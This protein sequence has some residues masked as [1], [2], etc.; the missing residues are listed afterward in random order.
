MNDSSNVVV[1]AD[2]LMSPDG[3]PPESAGALHAGRRRRSFLAAPR[4]HAET[5]KTESQDN[6]DD[7]LPVLTEVVPVASLAAEEP[8]TQA[9]PQTIDE[10]QVL[11]LATDIVHAIGKQMAYELP[12]LLEATLLNASDELR[13]GIASTMETAL[14]D[15]IA[16]RK[17]L[18]LPLGDPDAGEDTTH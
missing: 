5:E 13:A 6:E 1:R 3:S 12:S 18:A 15:Y 14:R 8:A 16:H 17:Q 7:D 2:T 9:I 4:S 11:T 10:A